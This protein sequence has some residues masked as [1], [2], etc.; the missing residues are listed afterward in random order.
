MAEKMTT[1]AGAAGE[2][3]L[4]GVTSPKKDPISQMKKA[5]GTWKNAMQAAI[6]SG[7]W[8]K[9]VA[10]IDEDEMYKIIREGGAGVFTSGISRRKGKIEKAY[11]LLRPKLLALASVLDAM[12]TDTDAARE[13]K[14]IAARRGMIKIGQE[15][16]GAK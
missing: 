3:W 16:K 15:L 11:G 12:P 1:N 6:S 2:R 14:M 10:A 7:S 9:A 13:A 8:E 4:A 5:A